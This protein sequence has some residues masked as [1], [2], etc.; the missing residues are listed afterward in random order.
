MRQLYVRQGLGVGQLRMKYGGLNKTKVRIGVI[1]KLAGSFWRL[2]QL[3][4]IAYLLQLQEKLL[5]HS[6]AAAA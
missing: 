5:E 2:Q 4:F 1:W 3:H 6:A